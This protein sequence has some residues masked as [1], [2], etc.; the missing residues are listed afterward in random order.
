MGKL[1]SWEMPRAHPED[2]ISPGD[3]D[4]LVLMDVDYEIKLRSLRN[5]FGGFLE[6]ISHTPEFK[7]DIHGAFSWHAPGWDLDPDVGSD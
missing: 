4:A 2:V 7:G 3:H 1:D 5:V 6:A